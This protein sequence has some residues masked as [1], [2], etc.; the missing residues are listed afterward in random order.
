LN[1]TDRHA[2]VLRFFYGKSMKEVGAV[3]GGSEDVAKMRLHRAVEKLRK[4]FLKRGV[5]STTATL[6]GAKSG[7][8]TQ[9]F[10]LLFPSVG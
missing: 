3:L 2:V 10:F 5:T 4:F 6:A 7:V 1:E 9:T 8:R